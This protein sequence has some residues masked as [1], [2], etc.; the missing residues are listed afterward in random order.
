MAA[1]TLFGANVAT[2]ILYRCSSCN[3]VVCTADLRLA[4]G[5]PVCSSKDFKRASL[6]SDDEMRAA[7]QR[8]F[9]YD[10]ADFDYVDD[11]LLKRGILPTWIHEPVA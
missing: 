1:G 5:C 2:D 7:I 4:P 10:E 9:Q 8:G 6:V 11:S 3:Q